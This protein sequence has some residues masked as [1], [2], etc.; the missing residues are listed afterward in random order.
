MDV[1]P[2]MVYALKVLRASANLLSPQQLS[3]LQ[4]LDAGGVFAEID[5]H[6]K[7]VASGCV[8]PQWVRRDFRGVFHA[9]HCEADHVS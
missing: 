9:A 1:T 8:C 4:V 5:A 6:V 3:A 7:A 2:A